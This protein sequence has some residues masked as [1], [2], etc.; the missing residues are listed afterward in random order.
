MTIISELDD[1]FKSIAQQQAVLIRESR[2][3]ERIRDTLLPKLMSGEIDV[4]EVEV[5][6]QLNNHLYGYSTQ[7][8]HQICSKY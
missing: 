3:L 5:P 2:N 8:R 4:T 6:T 1:A 7:L